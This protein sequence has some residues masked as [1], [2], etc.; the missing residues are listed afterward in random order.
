MHLMGMSKPVVAGLNVFFKEKS[1]SIR[2]E[3]GINSIQRC[4]EDMTKGFA[5]IK[6]K[7]Q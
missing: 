6:G 3:S 5:D 7:S 2:K 1:I 4:T